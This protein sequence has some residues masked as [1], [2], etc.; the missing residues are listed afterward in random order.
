MSWGPEPVGPVSVPE[1]RLSS[2]ACRPL[3]CFC[4]QLLPELSNPDELLPYLGPAG[5]PGSSG[6]DLLALFESS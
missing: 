5:L 2:P 6:D 1:G 3:R 4:L